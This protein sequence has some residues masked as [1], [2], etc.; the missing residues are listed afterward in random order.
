MKRFWE[1]HV[2]YRIARWLIHLG[3]VIWPEGP[4][5]Q[6][7]LALLGNWGRHVLQTINDGDRQ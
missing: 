4:A 3:F 6:Q 5:K 7:V 2:R 1:V